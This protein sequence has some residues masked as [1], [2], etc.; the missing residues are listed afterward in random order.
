LLVII[1]RTRRVVSGSTTADF[2]AAFMPTRPN[3]A[4]GFTRSAPIPSYLQQE[5]DHMADILLIVLGT[6]GI[7]LMAAYAAL[8]E[9]I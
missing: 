9:R 1:L 8:C 7:L 2:Y 4:R 5:A 3:P 6:G